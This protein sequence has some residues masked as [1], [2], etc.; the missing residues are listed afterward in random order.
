MRPSQALLN[1]MRRRPV[2]SKPAPH[3]P[4]RRRPVPP[5]PVPHNPARLWPLPLCRVHL[6]PASSSPPQMVRDRPR[7][8]RPSRPSAISLL[9]WRR[10]ILSSPRRPPRRLPRVPAVPSHAHLYR[11]LPPRRRRLVCRHRPRQGPR[12]LCRQ[13]PPPP[14]PRGLNP[15]RQARPRLW[16]RLAQ[17]LPARSRA[18]LC[19]VDQGGQ[20]RALASQLPPRAG[21]RRPFQELRPHGRLAR[22]QA[23]ARSTSSRSA[24]PAV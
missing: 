8:R 16:R 15:R 9:P 6:C 12:R 3:Y 7:P 14:R 20:S 1:P 11:H 22:R 23:P 4:T 2:P 13:P 19:R 24:P 10:G 21:G 18:H 17:L 5:K